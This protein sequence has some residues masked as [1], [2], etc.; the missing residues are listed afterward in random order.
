VSRETFHVG[1]GFCGVGSARAW[2]RDE[3]DQAS[4]LY[5]EPIERETGTVN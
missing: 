5:V 3:P 1:P 2:D 4:A